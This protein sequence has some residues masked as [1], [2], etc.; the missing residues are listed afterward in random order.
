MAQ[1]VDA[2]I[3]LGLPAALA[4][5]ADSTSGPSTEYRSSKAETQESTLN[6]TFKYWKLRFSLFSRFDEGIML[7]EASMYSVCPEV[8]AQHIAKR[9]T[10]FGTVLDPFC[11]AGGNVI[12][13]ALICDHVIAIDLDPKKI[14]LAKKNA[15]V[16]GVAHRIDFR[17]GNSFSVAT[18]LRVDAVVTSPPWGGPG[19]ERRAKFD[20]RDLCGRDTGGMAAIIRMARAVAPRVVLHVPKNIDKDQCLQI[21]MDEGFSQIQYESVSIDKKPNCL[22]L[23]L[24]RND[25]HTRGIPVQST[26]LLQLDNPSLNRQQKM[27]RL[28]TENKFMYKTYLNK[29]ARFFEKNHL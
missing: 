28:R 25:T 19:Y 29:V 11:G 4:P 12:Q 8:L 26:K 10:S 20:A 14:A 9:C 21:A 23:Y 5:T 27:E 22:N 17:V 16:Y 2:Q 24:T 15:E 7:D 18:N 1:L 13:L 6:Q 3:T